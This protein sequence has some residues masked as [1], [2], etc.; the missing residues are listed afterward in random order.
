MEMNNKL[1]KHE[2][3]VKPGFIYFLVEP[4][5]LYTVVG[6]SV[7]I[8]IF[9]TRNRYGGMTHY[10]R[11]IRKSSNN[12]TPLYACPAII[13][14]LNIFLNSG[15]QIEDLEASIYGGAEN[16]EAQGYI[17]GLSEENIRT[18]IEILELK[19]INIVTKET[20][21]KRGRKILF[22][23]SSGEVIVASVDKIR[24]TDWYPQIEE[25]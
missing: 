15:S 4:S 12:S 14:L 7:V 18:G 1:V 16:P 19:K 20:G 25:F 13:G 6:S 24:S 21:G 23:T 17:P 8:T 10:I 5:Y 2:I 9:D 3:F 22:N 11:P